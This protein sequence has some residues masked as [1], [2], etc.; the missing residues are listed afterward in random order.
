MT[1]LNRPTQ[2]EHPA[3]TWVRT[4]FQVVVGLAAAWGLIVEAA[5][6]DEASAFAV[7]TVAFSSAVTRVMALPQV[8]EL[9]NRFAPWL[10]A[11]PGL[12]VAIATNGLEVAT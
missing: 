3:R 11:A 6:V 9:I 4:G 7:A 5:G 1:T 10:A 8:N 2:V 12:E